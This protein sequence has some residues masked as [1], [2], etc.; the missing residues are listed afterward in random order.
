MPLSGEDVPKD[1][2]ILDAIERM[3]QLAREE[4]IEAKDAFA[5]RHVEGARNLVV[6]DAGIGRLN[7][8]FFDRA[9][10]IGVDVHARE[11]ALFMILVARSLERIGDNAVDMAEQTVFIVTVCSASSRT[12]RTTYRHLHSS[13]AAL[14]RASDPAL[15]PA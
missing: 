7:R 4:L 9:V 5:T 1:E 10:E 14:Q 8:A 15:D 2:E 6:Q 3:G 12:H 11:W 13:F